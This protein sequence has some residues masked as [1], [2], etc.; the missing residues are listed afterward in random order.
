VPKFKTNDEPLLYVSFGSLASG[1]A[2]LL[3][4]LIVHWQAGG[5]GHGQLRHESDHRQEDKKMK[6]KSKDMREQ[7]GPA[8]AAR[9]IDGLMRHRKAA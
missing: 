5:Q 9:V 6:A 4:R 2:D 8:K 1:D 7:K 3:K